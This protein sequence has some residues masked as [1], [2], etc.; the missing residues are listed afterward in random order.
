M[1]GCAQ[2]WKQDVGVTHVFNGCMYVAAVNL[3][4]TCLDTP[5]DGLLGKDDN[6]CTALWP[7]HDH[8]EVTHVAAVTHASMHAHARC[9]HARSL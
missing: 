3:G 7:A 1:I 8:C 2:A 6:A 9:S 4:V 5:I